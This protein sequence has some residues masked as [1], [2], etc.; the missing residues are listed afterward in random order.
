MIEPK[1]NAPQL[2]A[3]ILS[4][5]PTGNMTIVFSKSII[6]PPIVYEIQEQD[7]EKAVY[8]SKRDLGSQRSKFDINEAV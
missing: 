5:S 1:E 3:S 7:P 4:V 6:L 8:H 2:K